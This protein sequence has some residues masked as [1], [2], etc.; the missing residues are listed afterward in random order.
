MLIL[1][2]FVFFLRLVRV[3]LGLCFF[4]YLILIISI[5]IR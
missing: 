4:Y 1:F 2:C 5:I 3:L